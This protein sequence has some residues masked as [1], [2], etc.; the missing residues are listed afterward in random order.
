MTTR[1]LGISVLVALLVAVLLGVPGATGQT[2]GATEPRATV[3]NLMIPAGAFTPSE[4]DADY[5]NMG[6]VLEVFGAPATFNASLL[7]P[8]PTVSIRRITLYALDQD[9]SAAICVNLFR[10]RPADGASDYMGVV[11]TMDSGVDPQAPYSTAISPRSINTAL[12]GAS[13]WLGVEPGTRLYGVKITY[14]Y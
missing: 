12:H 6:D 13:L 9:S 11:C 4:D 3:G 1:R 14:S 2:G 8:V 5:A 10:D 7:F